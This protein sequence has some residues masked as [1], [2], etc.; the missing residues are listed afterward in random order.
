MLIPV[1]INIRE[2]LK[3]QKPPS[4]YRQKVGMGGLKLTIHTSLSLTFFQRE[5]EFLEASIIKC[6]VVTNKVS[7]DIGK[8]QLLQLSKRIF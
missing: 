5:R 6:L 1:S 3:V 4:P 7:L 8:L 2:S